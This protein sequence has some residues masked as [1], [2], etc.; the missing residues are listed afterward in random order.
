[1]GKIETWMLD[2]SQPNALLDNA[3]AAIE[4]GDGYRAELDKIRIPIYTTDTQGLVTYWNQACVDF[5]GREPQLGSDRWCVTWRLFTLDGDP[6]PHEQCPMAVAIREKRSIRTEVAVAM[7]PNGSRV[8]F[9]PYPTPLFNQAGELSGAINML[10]D[11]SDE[12][13]DALSEQAARCR[14]L[15]N[16][17]D[18]TAAR[19]ILRTMAKGYDDSAASLRHD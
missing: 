3:L 15:A 7:R 17:T 1:V 4:D 10:V 6:L 8:A 11:V 9:R 13:A 5:A 18:D 12:Q 16:S 19:N 14:R 2:S